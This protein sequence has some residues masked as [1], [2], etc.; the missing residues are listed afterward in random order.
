MI[1][2]PAN[3]FSNDS[4][5]WA[6]LQG[7]TEYAE[8]IAREIAAAVEQP[9]DKSTQI[10]IDVCLEQLAET[11]RKVIDLRDYD[12]LKWNEVAKQM[13]RLRSLHTMA[14]LIKRREIRLG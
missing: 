12:G 6:F 14:E 7:L 11:H 5:R 10:A 3:W 8:Y 9:V 4:E 13:M 1:E 2:R